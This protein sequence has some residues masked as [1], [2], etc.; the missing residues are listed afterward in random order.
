ME[1]VAEAVCRLERIRDWARRSLEAEEPLAE[2]DCAQVLAA[3]TG[4]R[5]RA[6]PIEL[7]TV[8]DPGPGAL[9]ARL[10]CCLREANEVYRR[11]AQERGPLSRALRRIGRGGS[12]VVRNYR[13]AYE[14]AL[15]LAHLS[16]AA[17]DRR[18]AARWLRPAGR[19]LEEYCEHSCPAQPFPA[20]AHDGVALQAQMEMGRQLREIFESDLARLRRLFEDTCRCVSRSAGA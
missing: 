8:A 12:S 20:A 3:A 6:V 14:T 11:N 9:Y 17:G 15:L 10:A 7:G 16:A 4:R 13:G 18:D 5:C 1:S 19:M 2:L